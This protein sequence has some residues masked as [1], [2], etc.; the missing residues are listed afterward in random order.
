MLCLSTLKLLRLDILQCNTTYSLVTVDKCWNKKNKWKTKTKGY[1]IDFR[2]IQ[3]PEQTAFQ[4]IFAK[5]CVQFSTQKIPIQT[6]SWQFD[7][8]Q[9]WNQRKIFSTIADRGTNAFLL[10][11]L[12]F[13]RWT[14]FWMFSFIL[15]KKRFKFE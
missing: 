4:N 13:F 15:F 8:C 9:N 7:T 1:P 6:I 14:Y 5:N 2:S 10:F 12:V 11:Y 3:F